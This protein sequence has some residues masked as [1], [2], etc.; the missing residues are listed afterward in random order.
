MNVTAGHDSN[1]S[2]ARGEYKKWWKRM[3]ESGNK[4]FDKYLVREKWWKV[5]MNGGYR[6]WLWNVDVWIGRM[7]RKC[8]SIW[9]FFSWCEVTNSSKKGGTC[10]DVVKT[11]SMCTNSYC[12]V[13]CMSEKTGRSLTKLQSCA[14]WK[15][16]RDDE[17]AFAGE[18]Y[19]EIRENSTKCQCWNAGM[20]N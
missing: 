8:V 13:L 15:A 14:L 7:Y 10:R 6:K 1:R 19:S 2:G 3:F 9:I 20:A 17:R 18:K 12:F 11:M 5:W 4:L 16:T